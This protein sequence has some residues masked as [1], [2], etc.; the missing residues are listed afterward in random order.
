[1][2]FLHEPDGLA[3][4]IHVVAHV[5]LLVGGDGLEFLVECDFVAQILNQLAQRE[6]RVGLELLGADVVGDR[7][8]RVGAKQ[9]GLVHMRVEDLAGLL[10]RRDKLLHVRGCYRVVQRVGSGHR[11]DQ[12]QH[13]QSHALLPVI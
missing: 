8:A 2:V 5:G 7:G 13:D 4:H 11:A 12:D 3:G 1:M 10:R 9:A 6:N